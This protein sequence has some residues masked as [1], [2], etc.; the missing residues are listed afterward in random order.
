MG[1]AVTNHVFGHTFLL[2]TQGCT[3]CFVAMASKRSP[4]SSDD[5]N[6]PSKSLLAKYPRTTMEEGAPIKVGILG[7]TGMVGQ[8][9]IVLL[10]AHPWFVIHGL[11]ASPRSTGKQYAK[12]AHWK[13]TTPIPPDVRD[14]IVT[15][16]NPGSFADCTIVFSGLDADAAGDIGS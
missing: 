14:M 16:C 6:S 10:S 13:Q 7:A 11:G 8:R 12:A 4:E 3:S 9:F 5:V 15:E 1:V 2:Q